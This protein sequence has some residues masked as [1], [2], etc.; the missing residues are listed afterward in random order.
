MRSVF[1]FLSSL[2]CLLIIGCAEV[3]VP[4]PKD[5]MTHPFGTKQARIGWTKEEVKM[6][7]GDPDQIISMEPDPWGNPQEE[8]VY[9]GRYPNVP[10]D[11]KFL[12]KTKHFYFS[13]DVLVQFKSDQSDSDQQEGLE[14][15]EK[16]EWME[17][18]ERAE[19]E[20]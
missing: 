10:I 8:W 14:K 13:G 5:V 4:T 20:K 6:K 16:Q 15:E 12:S 17:N 1:C 9:T 3:D 18:R 2:F 19:K 7:W 11:Y